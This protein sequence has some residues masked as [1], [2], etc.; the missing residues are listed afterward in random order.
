[1]LGVRPWDSTAAMSKLRFHVS[2][3]AR[4]VGGQEAL[5]AYKDMSIAS[6]AL[7]AEVDEARKL[8]RPHASDSITHLRFR[9]APD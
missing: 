6:K 2:T 8:L 9:H 3:D 5:G 1:M 7:N 4:G